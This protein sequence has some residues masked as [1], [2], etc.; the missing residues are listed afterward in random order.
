MAKDENRV[1]VAAEERESGF[2]GHRVRGR[3]GCVPGP[4]DE[5]DE[6]LQM[7]RAYSITVPNANAKLCEKL[8]G[9]WR[10]ITSTTS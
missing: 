6:V 8:A 3:R 7:V 5:T 2:R 1:D 9:F 10:G 4:S